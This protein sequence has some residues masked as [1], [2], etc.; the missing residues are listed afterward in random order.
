MFEGAITAKATL[1]SRILTLNSDLVGIS[2]MSTQ[3]D[4]SSFSAVAATIQ[5]M[6]QKRPEGETGALLYT[7]CKNRA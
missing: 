1:R 2:I 4:K 7:A 3:Q 5:A 6:K